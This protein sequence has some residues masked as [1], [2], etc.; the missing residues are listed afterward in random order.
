VST[1]GSSALVTVPWLTISVTPAG[2]GESMMTSKNTTAPAP[3]ETS[4]RET[5]TGASE[6]TVPCEATTEPGTT[7]VCA[8][9]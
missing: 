3:A 7:V 8:G 4:P 6:M 1:A 5:S 9:A 2:T